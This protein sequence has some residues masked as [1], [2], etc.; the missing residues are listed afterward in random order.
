M[1]VIE[2][3]IIEKE[4]PARSKPRPR[5]V[6]IQKLERVLHI[7]RL[8]R[9][10]RRGIG[11]LGVW[12]VSFS[13]FLLVYGEQVNLHEVFFYSV[14]L[15]FIILAT[16][17][18]GTKEAEQVTSEATFNVAR[19]LPA[20]FVWGIGIFLFM[21]SLFMLMGAQIGPPSNFDIMR[22]LL[23]VVP[24]ETLLFIIFLPAVLDAGIFDKIPYVPGWV[25]SAGIF[26]GMHVVSGSMTLSMGFFA[27]LMGVLWYIMYSAGRMKGDYGQYFGLGSVL[28]FHFTWN[29]MAMSVKTEVVAD[30]LVV[31]F[32]L[33]G[34]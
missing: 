6:I 22:Q 33:M 3:P 31:L 15:I 29:I 11:F 30:P 28:A 4:K 34:L 17:M 9:R 20:L 2:I 10:Q 23:I 27:G 21:L 25:A 12:T 14:F 1:K 8:P 7:E 19:I 16:F 24:F 32:K 18:I 5:P 13:T 26:G